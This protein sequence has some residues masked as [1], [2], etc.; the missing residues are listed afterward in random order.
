M[1]YIWSGKK[2]YIMAGWWMGSN[3]LLGLPVVRT[4]LSG[5]P[6]VIA[7]RSELHYLCS[8]VCIQDVFIDK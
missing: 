3:K 4:T 8:D 7:M 2:S 5:L 1:C 6:V